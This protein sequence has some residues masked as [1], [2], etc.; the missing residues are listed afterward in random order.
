MELEGH[1]IGVLR[2]SLERVALGDEE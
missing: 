1:A 2:K